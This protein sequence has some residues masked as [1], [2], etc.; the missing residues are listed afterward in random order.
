MNIGKFN[1]T[2]YIKWSLQVEVLLER[3]DVIEVITGDLKKP[4]ALGENATTAERLSYVDQHGY[5]RVMGTTWDKLQVKSQEVEVPYLEKTFASMADVAD[6]G[7]TTPSEEITNMLEREEM[8]KW[9]K[10]LG[11]DTLLFAKKG[12]AKRKSKDNK[13]KGKSN[14]K[15]DKK[16]QV[17]AIRPVIIT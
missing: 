10:N 9:E 17:L 3:N 12:K 4:E 5:Q 7:K 11:Y 2:N 6:N 1:R 13:G 15:K 14:V 16:S 8:L